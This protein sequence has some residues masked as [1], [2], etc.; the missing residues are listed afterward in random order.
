[1]LIDSEASHNFI[2]H[3]LVLKLG[4]PINYFAGMHIILGDG[5]RIW[6]HECCTEIDIKLGEFSCTLTTL[7]FDFGNLDM[8]LGID[9][10][11]K[12]GEVVHI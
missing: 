6:A 5:H 11:T 10:L 7:I 4:L 12:L 9:W 1:M 2:S 3:K 8:V